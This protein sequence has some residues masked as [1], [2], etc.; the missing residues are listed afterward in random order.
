MKKRKRLIWHLYPPYLALIL[1]SLMAVSFFTSRSLH[2][3]FIDQ[4]R[5][6]LETHALIVRGQLQETIDFENANVLDAFCKDIGKNTTIRITIIL[7]DGRV[8]GD[9]NENAR[10]IGNHANRPEIQDA[11]RGQIGTSERFSNTLQQNMMYL[12]LPVTRD[13]RVLAVIRTAIPLTNV[14]DEINSL[15]L[16]IG[17][18][19]FII[20]IVAALICLFVSHRISSPIGAITKGA[21][22]FAMGDLKHRLSSPDTVEMSGVTKALNQMAGEL[23]N[24]ME[25][26]INQR[27]E[28]EAVLTSMVEGVIAI[29]MEEFILSINR[30][31]A[32]MLAANHENLKGRRI[33]E[34]VRNRGLHQFITE[35]LGDGNPKEGDVVM[36]QVGEQVMHTQCIPLNNASGDRIGTLVVLHDVTR[37]RRLENR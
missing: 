3:F 13:G 5:S 27:N 8:V 25:A 15:Q 22:R 2:G 14:E 30:A 31:A 29:D 20:A 26:V 6:E 32:D 16:K 35:A 34:S 12:A 4:T 11:Y 19:G 10:N 1:L 33:L 17:F 24:R 7:S 28:Y 21:N 37:I 23:E 9:S 18:F 36:H